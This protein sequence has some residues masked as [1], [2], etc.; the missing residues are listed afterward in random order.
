[1]EATRASDTLGQAFDFNRD[2]IEFIGVFQISWL[3]E[4]LCNLPLLLII[5]D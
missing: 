5:K 2:E 3:I 1:M 4:G